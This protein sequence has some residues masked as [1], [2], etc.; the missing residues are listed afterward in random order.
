M[1]A[2]WKDGYTEWICSIENNLTYYDCAVV[3]E[4]LFGSAIN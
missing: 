1:N 2:L 4:D 3:S